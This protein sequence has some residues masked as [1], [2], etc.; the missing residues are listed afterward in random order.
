MSS[1][2]PCGHF[3][4]LHDVQPSTTEGCIECLQMGSPWVHLRICLACGHVGCCDD[5]PMRHATAHFRATKHPVIKSFEPGETWGW[6][7]LDSTMYD[8]VPG[9]TPRRHIAPRTR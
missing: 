1:P 9:P 3:D 7:Y 2:Y 8:P 4:A 6:C 5:S